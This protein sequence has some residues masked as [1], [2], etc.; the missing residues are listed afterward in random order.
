V[1]DG[2]TTPAEARAD[3][4]RDAAAG[5]ERRGELPDEPLPDEQITLD[6]DFRLVFVNA[7]AARGL[8]APAEA[9][10]GRSCWAVRPEWLGTA[11]ERQWRRVAAARVAVRFAHRESRDG[12][13]VRFEIDAYPIDGGGIAVFRRET[14][15]LARAEEASRTSDERYVALFESLD[16]GFC[17]IEILVDAEGRPLDYRFCEANEAFSRQTGLVDAVG[18]TARELVPGLEEHW[19]EV[20]GRVASTGEPRR[21]QNGSGPMGRYFDV[22]AFPVGPPARRRVGILF[23]DVSA[24]F[25]AERER[26]ELVRALEVERARLA[27]VFEQAPAFLAVLRGPEHVVELANGAY[28]Q[29]V[30]HRPIVGRP[31]FEA[32]PEVREQ[33]YRELLDRVIETGVPFVGRELPLLVARTPGAPAE[34]RYVDL[35][36][37]PLVEGDGSRT[38]IIAHGT[39]VT[40]QVVARRE[41]E[42]L[43][44][45]SETARAQSERS[46]AEAERAR[47][48]IARLQ[49]LTAALARAGTVEDVAN[50]VV[51]E[52]VVALGARTGALSVR[53]ADGEAL[54]FARTVGFPTPVVD[55][56]ARQPLTLRSPLS[57][58]F[59][60]REPVWIEERGGPDGL[61]LRYPPM[62]PVWDAVGLQSAA[63]VP[64]VA[65][66]DAVGAISFGFAEPRR[67]TTGERAFLLALGQQAA[68]AMERAR[69]FD[70]EHAAR[71]DAEA[72]NRAKAEFLAV[73]SHELRTPLNAIGGYAELIELGIRGPITD[74]QRADLARIQMSQRHLLGLINQVL[75]Y[76][77][78]E[79]GAVEYDLVGVRVGDALAGA[80]ALIV[81]QVRAK[82]LT[83]RVGDCEPGLAVRADREKLQQILLNLLTNA[84][85]FTDAGGGLHVACA[86]RGASVAISVR[87]T[88]IGIAADRLANVF[89]PFVQVD[90]R[91]TRPHEG[92]GL[93]LAISRDLARG[94]GGD[95]TVE[96]ALGV[97]STFTLTLPRVG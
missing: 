25:A 82:G 89:D 90:Q 86:A 35:A 67:F 2:R 80:E 38:G 87:D 14:T 11:V 94:M 5:W 62:A 72:A 54:V 53:S 50:V 66:G 4:T 64:L 41:V 43:L 95:L 18:R 55:A 97:G 69:L 65:A 75:N 52:M 21:F 83:Y 29:L 45:A 8:G 76:A 88:G 9:L 7:A 79:T 31:L 59:V 70:A 44:A 84:I 34:E 73:M 28:Y 42:R 17:V 10:V 32:L 24:A 61:D 3:G 96:S 37:M 36:Y 91:L 19:I 56:V 6:A 74:A 15:A 39:D 58:C 71:Q 22:Y 63:F 49:A 30:G 23:S 33:G 81:P 46:Q 60:A 48:R 57:E 1:S 16:Q 93:G 77:R 20:Y 27:Y 47:E 12:A 92:V 40:A 51:A 13:D 26:A 78:V 85:K 68:L